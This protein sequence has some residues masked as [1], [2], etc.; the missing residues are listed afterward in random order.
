M[1][2]IFISAVTL[3]SIGTLTYAAFAG[4]KRQMIVFDC[5]VPITGTARCGDPDQNV[6]VGPEQRVAVDWTVSSDT[7]SETCVTFA[8]FHAVSHEHLRTKQ[9]CGV[10]AAGALWT[11][12]DKKS[13]D[14]YITV[15]SNAKTKMTIKGFY[16][17]ARP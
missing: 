17:V 16:H 2:H 10:P 8:Q 11:N 15:G 9:L 14:T 4:E 6:R 12:L 7:D 3:T 5:T 13:V 1:R